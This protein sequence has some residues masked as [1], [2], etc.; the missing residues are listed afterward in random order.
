MT[1]LSIKSRLEILGGRTIVSLGMFTILLAN[2]FQFILRGSIESFYKQSP[3]RQS[4][5][6]ALALFLVFS[7]VVNMVMRS[8]GMDLMQN[9]VVL[10]AS[11]SILFF[12]VRMEKKIDWSQHLLIILCAQQ[13]LL[14]ESLSEIMWINVFSWFAIAVSSGMFLFH[15]RKYWLQKSELLS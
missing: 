4:L 13:I 15:F 12:M 5:F 10:I 9:L 1:E 11:L 14:N 7:A 3:E 2:F 8:L 6:V